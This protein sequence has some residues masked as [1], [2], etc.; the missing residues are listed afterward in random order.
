VVLL[1]LLLG[2]TSFVL[3]THQPGALAA[4]GTFEESAGIVLLEPEKWVGKPAPILKYIDIGKELAMGT[5]F[6]VLYH[7]DCPK[8][9][10]AL[11]RYESMARNSQNTRVALIAVPPYGDVEFA[12]VPPE[13]ACRVGFLQPAQ[14]WFVTTPAE[15][16]LRD[17]MVMPLAGN[18]LATAE[19]PAKASIHSQGD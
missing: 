2:G 7:Y 14:R 12:P 3:G 10:E 15:I 17:G 5:W 9:Q 11:P 19:K 1:F 6:V 8:C 18:P 4:D 16:I 13:S